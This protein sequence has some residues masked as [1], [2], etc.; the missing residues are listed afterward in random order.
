MEKKEI[1][2]IDSKKKKEE[3]II[4]KVQK[5]LDKEKS[6]IKISHITHKT[7]IFSK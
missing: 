2:K 3:K 7:I 1:N 4:K 6:P 5:A